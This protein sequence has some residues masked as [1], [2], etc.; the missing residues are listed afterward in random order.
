MRYPLARLPP[1]LDFRFCVRVKTTLTNTH[2]TASYARA[3]QP[4]RASRSFS[5]HMDS[6]HR[7]LPHPHLHT[8]PHLDRI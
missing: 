6:A 1:S 5:L 4:R 3:L 8:F 7:S 2:D